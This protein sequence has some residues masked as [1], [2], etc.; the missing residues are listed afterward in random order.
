MSLFFLY[1]EVA[2]FPKS[3]MDTGGIWRSTPYAKPCVQASEE[4]DFAA[5]CRGSYTLLRGEMFTRYFFRRFEDSLSSFHHSWRHT[6][7]F[8]Y[9]AADIIILTTHTYR[10]MMEVPRHID[11]LFKYLLVVPSLATLDCIWLLDL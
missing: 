10:L 9:I 8:A 7:S 1:H 6:E 4:G 2:T 5:K 11:N 3:T